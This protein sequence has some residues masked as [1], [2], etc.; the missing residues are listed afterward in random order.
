MAFVHR[1]TRESNKVNFQI[2][3][4]ATEVGPGA[5]ALPSGN[6]ETR[7]SYA[8]FQSTSSRIQFAGGATPGPGTYHRADNPQHITNSLTGAFKSRTQRFS[9]PEFDEDDQLPGPGQ[10]TPSLSWTKRNRAKRA[11]TA[12]SSSSKVKWVRVPSAP[13]IPGRSDQYGYEENER[14]GLVKQPPPVEGHSGTKGNTVGPGM[15][16]VERVPPRSRTRGAVSF[17]LSRTLR[18]TA[19]KAETIPGPGAYENSGRL[20]AGQ[21]ERGSAAFKS[22]SKRS[23]LEIG[24]GGSSVGPGNY[25]LGGAFGNQKA[26]EKMQFFG[27]TSRRFKEKATSRNPGPGAYGVNKVTKRIRGSEARRTKGTKRGVGFASTSRRFGTCRVAA[28]KSPGVGT[29]M[30]KGF[31]ERIMSQNAKSRRGVFGSSTARFKAQGR[32]KNAAP[33]PGSY[34]DHFVSVS[35]QRSQAKASSFFSSGAM[36]FKPKAQKDGPDPGAYDLSV[37]WEKGNPESG[38]MTGMNERFNAAP[39]CSDGPGPGAYDLTKVTAMSRR[40]PHAVHNRKAILVSQEKRFFRP[41]A[42][43]TTPGPGAY[44]AEFLYGNMNKATYNITIAEEMFA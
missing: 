33:G 37:S 16:R 28:G 24:S 2:P 10:Y 23:N 13:S 42:K 20:R 35:K 41:T 25:T 34:S 27:S 43:D 1:T 6:W 29:Y 8:P 38:I 19:A 30:M 14:G 18:S 40:P 4:T 22:K 11:S 3:Q 31:A 9:A 26:P 12:C 15:Y 21:P 7:P 32:K 36:R 5:Y 17:G 44:D 39:P